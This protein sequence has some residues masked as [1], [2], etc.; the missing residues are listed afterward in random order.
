MRLGVEQTRRY[1]DDF[2][3]VLV[4]LGATDRLRSFVLPSFPMLMLARERLA[5]T[6]VGYGAQ[7]VHWQPTG[8][9]TGEVAAETLAELGCSYAEIGHSER[10]AHFAETDQTVA[11]KVGACVRTGLTPVICVGEVDQ[12]TS[13]RAAR[14]TGDQVSSAVSTVPD[15]YPV[16]IAYEPAW[17]IGADDAARPAHILTVAQTIRERLGDA[18]VAG[19]VLYGG[20][21]GPGL[22][23]RLSKGGPRVVDGLF[24]GRSAL[25]PVR[26]RATLAE[27]AGVARPA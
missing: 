4:E 13:E 15:G 10:R 5:T 2:C 27:V 8:A 14:I 6:P 1:L 3:A 21:A 12:T 22:F 17:A 11:A 24:L 20:S 19:A 18:T 16:M 9:W 26:L 23:T 25:D 7:N